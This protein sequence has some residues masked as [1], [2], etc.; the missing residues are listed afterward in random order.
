MVLNPAPHWVLLRGL[1]REAAHWGAFPALLQQT[2]PQATLHLLDLPGNGARHQERSPATVAA[3]VADVRQQVAQRGIPAPVHLL[4]LSLGA[5]VAVEWAH[6]APQE[7]AGAVLVNTS[8][9]PFSPLHH[10]LLPRNYPALLRLALS[11][12]PADAVE[13]AIFRMT[14]N[15]PA[16]QEATVSRWA[17]VREQRPVRA[18]NALRQLLAAARYRARLPAPGVPIL[19]LG[20]AQDHLVSSHCTLAIA[21][22]WGCA[23]R[24]HPSAGHDLPQD[25]PAWVAR[26]VRDWLAPPAA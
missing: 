6:T 10:R 20:S 16:Q 22:A 4:A 5:M 13:R 17:A 25:D 23:L 21:E 7:L 8:L 14:C 18:G 2:L 9:R 26:Q 24:I 11:R 1:T 19:L 3:M 15:H 12:P